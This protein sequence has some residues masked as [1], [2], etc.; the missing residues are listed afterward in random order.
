[1]EEPTGERGGTGEPPIPGDDRRTILETYNVPPVLFGYVCVVAFFLLYQGAGALASFL[2]YGL[3]PGADQMGGYRVFT[4]IAQIVLLL[5]PT[6]VVAHLAT[7]SPWEYM[8]LKWPAPSVLL[9]PVVGIFSLQQMLQVYMVFQGRIPIPE[10]LRE[11]FRAL[12]EMIEQAYTFL[13]AADSP[14]E[15]FVVILVIAV[16][17]AFS[18]EFFFRGLLQRSFEKG[19]GPLRGIMV[20]GIIF[21]AF[22]MNPFSIVPLV[23]LGVYLGFLA[24]RANSVWVSVVAHFVNNLLATLAVYL[25]LGEDTLVTGD[26]GDMSLGTLMMTFWFSGVIFLLSTYYFLH[27]T[28]APGSGPGDNRTTP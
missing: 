26:P 13:L 24:Y 17:P 12:Q 6:I 4:G 3:M 16:I 20:T 19:L 15:L 1:M 22:H 28:R 14:P 18:E 23:I 10:A 9:V 8:R 27:L 21:G 11:Q 2:I 25:G 7:R 5:I